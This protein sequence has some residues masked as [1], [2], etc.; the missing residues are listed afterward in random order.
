MK[1]KQNPFEWKKYEEEDQK[2]RRAL[3][4]LPFEQKVEMLKR[5]QEIG[6]NFRSPKKRKMP[7]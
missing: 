6:R 5:L 1:E 3:A 2:S 7:L 4:K